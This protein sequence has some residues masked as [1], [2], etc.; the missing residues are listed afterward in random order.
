MLIVLIV[1]MLIFMIMMLGYEAKSDKIAHRIDPRH[2][3]PGENDP[4][5]NGHSAQAS[6]NAN[7]NANDNDNDNGHSA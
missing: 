7:D 3:V 1:L 4:D 2:N 5:D 6:F